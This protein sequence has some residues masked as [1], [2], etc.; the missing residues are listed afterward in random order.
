MEILFLLSSRVKRRER[1][2]T[3]NEVGSFSLKILGDTNFWRCKLSQILTEFANL[4]Y[5]RNLRKLLIRKNKYPRNVLKAVSY[6]NKQNTC[7]KDDFLMVNVY[8]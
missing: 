6:E 3:G 4:K 1:R 8:R 2:S 5:Q 7:E